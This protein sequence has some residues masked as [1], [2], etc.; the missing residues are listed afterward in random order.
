MNPLVF[1][2]EGSFLLLEV[3]LSVVFL[4]L[5]DTPKAVPIY[6]PNGGR[7]HSVPFLHEPYGF[8]PTKML[9]QLVLADAGNGRDSI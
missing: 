5:G 2:R 6:P 9:Q 3:S 4:T 8:K 1:I 7:V